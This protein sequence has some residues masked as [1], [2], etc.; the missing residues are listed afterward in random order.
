MGYYEDPVLQLEYILF[1]E[2]AST[3]GDLTWQHLIRQQLLGN[4]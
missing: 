2:K 4:V 1:E 3:W